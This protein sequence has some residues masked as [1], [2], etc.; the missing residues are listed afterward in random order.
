MRL[1]NLTSIVNLYEGLGAEEFKEVINRWVLIKNLPLNKIVVK[2]IVS[3]FNETPNVVVNE[4]L[5]T[6]YEGFWVVRSDRGSEIRL[7]DGSRLSVGC[8][9]YAVGNGLMLKACDDMLTLFNIITG[10]E[11]VLLRGYDDVEVR[12]L[13][14][15]ITSISSNHRKFLVIPQ[16]KDKVIEVQDLHYVDSRTTALVVFK[17]RRKY[18]AAMCFKFL[19]LGKI[20]ELDRCTSVEELLVGDGL[21]IIRCSNSN[22]LISIIEAL[23]IPFTLEPIAHVNHEYVLYDR[24]F[25][26]LVRFDGRNFNQLLIPSKPKVVGKLRSGELITISNGNPYM[27]IGNVWKVI[28]RSKA[29]Y[30]GVGGDY[31]I[32]RSSR[33]LELYMRTS[34][35]S[36]FRPLECGLINENLICIHDGNILTYDLDELYDADIR[37]DKADLSVDG[38]PTLTITPW[39]S[40]SRLLIKGPV[41]IHYKN[42]EGSSKSKSFSVKPLILGKELKFKVILDAV[43]AQVV[44]ELGIRSSRVELKDSIIDEVKQSL[45]GFVDGTEE[46][47]LVKMCLKVFNPTPDEVQLSITYLANSGGG[48]E[49]LKQNSHI[50]RPG[51]NDLTITDTLKTNDKALQILMTYRWFSRNEHVGVITLDLSKYLVEDPLSSLSYKIKMLGTC[52]SKL[53]VSP[54]FLRGVEVP[55]KLTVTCSNNKVFH[56]VNEVILNECLLPAVVEYSYGYDGITWRKYSIVRG[57]APINL[58]LGFGSDLKPYVSENIRCVDG[59]LL[60]DIKLDVR[61]AY[62]I[63]WLGI[64]PCMGSV[65]NVKLKIS[66]NLL[67]DGV[68]LALVGGRTAYLVGSRGVLELEV[69]DLINGDLKVVVLCNG[70]KEVLTVD[71]TALI[72]KY[73]ELGF[74][75]ATL[76]KNKLLILGGMWG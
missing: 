18:Y 58:N 24:S 47:T 40:N 33:S 37:L 56:G 38:Y 26:V 5:T 35:I 68:V 4:D 61:S 75:T 74:N 60:K 65:G 30:G 44:N 64:E 45:N 57:E 13:G 10:D 76:L 23:K 20:Y 41:E 52:S 42:C 16:I 66:Y 53:V 28:T 2:P 49:I 34:H 69:E 9:V 63:S 71:N 51:I 48:D 62:P 59:L 12:G 27:V 17:N 3:S 54:S 1:P 36:S 25:N 6:T 46:N 31:I 29:L 67:G 73:L 70:F 72:K 8:E 7:L 21:G 43:L 22:Y 11:E 39:Y 15:S 14:G 50:L 32:L 55:I 19:N